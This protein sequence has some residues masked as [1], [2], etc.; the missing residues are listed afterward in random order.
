MIITRVSTQWIKRL[1]KTTTYKMTEKFFNQ[2]SLLWLDARREQGKWWKF[3][4]C[5][6]EKVGLMNEGFTSYVASIR[7]DC[8][9][10]ICEIF[11]VTQ[12]PT[13]TLHSLL[14]SATCE[15]LLP[16]SICGCAQVKS[17]DIY[18]WVF[19]SFASSLKCCSVA[20]INDS[21]K[22]FRHRL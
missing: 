9:R 12:T 19:M 11:S 6:I 15:L 22:A 14:V 1:F 7:I 13:L 18:S 5:V 2:C 4:L 8:D 20:I 10:R 17:V 16:V 21:L 3:A